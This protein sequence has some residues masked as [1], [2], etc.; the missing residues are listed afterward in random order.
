[1]APNFVSAARSK[2]TESGGNIVEG[3]AC[4]TNIELSCQFFTINNANNGYSSEK[5]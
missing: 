4:K 2:V 1:M 5:L 3:G